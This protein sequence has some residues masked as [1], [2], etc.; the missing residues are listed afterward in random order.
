MVS[1]SRSACTI[2]LTSLRHEQEMPLSLVLDAAFLDLSEKDEAKASGPVSLEGICSL[3][4]EYVVLQLSIKAQ[5]LLPCAMCNEPFTYEV[6]IENLCHQEHV[7]DKRHP[8]WDFSE[9]IREAILLELPFFPQ[10][11]QAENQKKCLRFDEVKKYLVSQKSDAQQDEVH[12]PFKEF[13]SI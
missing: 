4:D 9:V 10:C 5:F 1:M 8:T 11:G 7:G 2:D 12:T 3:V 13:F 6:F